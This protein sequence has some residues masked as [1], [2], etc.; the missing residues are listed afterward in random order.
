MA[1][2]T[3]KKLCPAQGMMDR[4]KKKVKEWKY[5]GSNFSDRSGNSSHSLNIRGRS[6][7]KQSRIG[8]GTRVSIIIFFWGW[9]FKRERGKNCRDS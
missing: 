9:S 4:K 3:K 6:G 7:V 5:L 2:P 1:F 8:R